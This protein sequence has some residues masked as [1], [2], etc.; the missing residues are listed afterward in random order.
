MTTAPFHPDVKSDE[1]GLFL[2][3]SESVFEIIDSPLK[4]MLHFLTLH[5]CKIWKKTLSLQLQKGMVNKNLRSHNDKKTVLKLN[6]FKK[7][8]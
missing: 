7:Y 1:M 8:Y 2:C 3:V 5:L 6:L 4:Q